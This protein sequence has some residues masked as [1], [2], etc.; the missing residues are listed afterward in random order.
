MKKLLTP[1]LTTSLV[2]SSLVALPLL[3][4][5]AQADTKARL[6][7]SD[8]DSKPI[9]KH[10]KVRVTVEVEIEASITNTDE[11]LVEKMPTQVTLQGPNGA[12]ASKKISSDEY[13]TGSLQVTVPSIRKAKS[14]LNFTVTTSGNGINLTKTKT[15]TMP[16]MNTKKAKFHKATKSLCDGKWMYSKAMLDFRSEFPMVK[17]P[18]AKKFKNPRNDFITITRAG[19]YRYK[20]RSESRHLRGFYT[21]YSKTKK[22]KITKKQL[23]QVKTLRSVGLGNGQNLIQRSC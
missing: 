16:A 20:N 4:S 6:T 10:T 13:Y 21:P 12:K 7:F 1:I 15:I 17:A 9:V 2:A 11:G 18:G 5:P 14:K 8:L 23:Q 19:V 22:I 3:A